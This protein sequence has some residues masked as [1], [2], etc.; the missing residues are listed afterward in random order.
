MNFSLLAA[1]EFSVFLEKIKQIKIESSTTNEEA[2][3]FNLFM[4]MVLELFSHT[5]ET[6]KLRLKNIFYAA[7][8]LKMKNFIIKLIKSIIKFIE[9][10]D[11]II[12]FMKFIIK[13]MKFLDFIIKFITFIIKFLNFIIKL[14]NFIIKFINFLNFI[15]K[16]FNFTNKIHF[17]S[18]IKMK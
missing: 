18:L 9:F 15:I 1:E 2:I 14:M 12:K 5:K 3:E 8:V 7:D 13:F 16:S 10:Y 17:K 6:V 4:K 11:F